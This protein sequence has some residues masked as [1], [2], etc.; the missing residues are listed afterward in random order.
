MSE[1]RLIQKLT[2]AMPTIRK[3]RGKAD[4]HQGTFLKWITS[5]SPLICWE[6]AA[7]Q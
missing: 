6:F 7:L 5:E 1:S 3:K 2:D 4:V